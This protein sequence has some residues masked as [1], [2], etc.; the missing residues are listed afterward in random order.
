M[1]PPKLYQQQP[2]SKL[3]VIKLSVDVTKIDK[4]SLYKGAKGTY[5]DL[6]V[7]LDGDPDQYG[8]HGMITQEI[9]RERRDAGEKGPILGNVKKWYP[10]EGQSQQQAPATIMGNGERRSADA[11]LDDDVDPLPF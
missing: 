11:N 9:S 6:T 4:N 1:H 3:G 10:A 8:Q 7:F 5:L 2:M